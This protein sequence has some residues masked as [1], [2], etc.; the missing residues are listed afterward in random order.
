MIKQQRSNFHTL[1]LVVDDKTSSYAEVLIRGQEITF[2]SK[3][4]E[5][6]TIGMGLEDLVP[7]P[8]HITVHVILDAMIASE[9]KCFVFQNGVITRGNCA[10]ID[11]L[12][13]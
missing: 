11:G 3:N 9:E 4:A 13:I 6:H 12:R 1:S 8:K 7:S 10:G 2:F 5:P